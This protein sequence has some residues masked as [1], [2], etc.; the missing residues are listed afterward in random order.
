MQ[1]K[2]LAA[3]SVAAILMTAA[4]ANATTM[5][6]EIEPNNTFATGQNTGY[7]DGSIH[8]TG[9]KESGGINDWFLFEGTAG[10]AITILTSKISGG[11][12]F[13]DTTLTLKDPWGTQL[14]Y[15]DD[16]LPYTGDPASKIEYTLLTTGLYGIGVGAWANCC[17]FEYAMDITGLT[18]NPEPI[19]TPPPHHTT[20]VP[21]PGTLALFGLGLAGLGFAR[22]RKVS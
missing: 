19:H 6:N 7:H 12:P 10:D 2:F 11:H 14:A 15:N 16:I 13:F 21:E 5:I 20:D 3:A 1:N 9:Y 4:A 17:T 8:I 18:P 22:R